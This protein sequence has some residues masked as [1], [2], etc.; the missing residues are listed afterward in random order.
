MTTEPNLDAALDSLTFAALRQHSANSVQHRAFVPLEVV[1]DDR[2]VSTLPDCVDQ[3]Q[4]LML[5]GEPGAGKTELARWVSSC[6]Q[7]AYLHG[8]RRGCPLLLDARSLAGVASVGHLASRLADQLRYF[9]QAVRADQVSMLISDR[10]VELIVDGLDELPTAHDRVNIVTVVRMLVS[11]GVLAWLTTRPID[12]LPPHGLTEARIWPLTDGQVKALFAQFVRESL[13]PLETGDRNDDEVATLQRIIDRYEQ[14]D[15]DSKG[16][17]R[18]PL[19]ARLFYLEESARKDSSFTIT[20]IYTDRVEALLRRSARQ[21][22]ARPQRLALSIADILYIFQTASA[23]AFAAGSSVLT[24]DDLLSVVDLTGSRADELIDICANQSGLLTPV[25]THSYAFIHKTFF[26]FFVARALSTDLTDPLTIIEHDTILVFLCGLASDPAGVIA[27]VMDYRGVVLT[28]RCLRELSQMGRQT[29]HVLIDRLLSLIDGGI[30]PLLGRALSENVASLPPRSV[31]GRFRGPGKKR[32]DEQWM[33]ARSS[34]S[35]NE[36]GRAF[37]LFAVEYF[38]TFFEVVRHDLRTDLGQIDLLLENH[39]DGLF[40][41]DLGG[42]ALVECKNLRARATISDVNAFLAKVHKRLRFS[43]IVSASGFT[44]DARDRLKL[45]VGE[46]GPLVVP[47]DGDDIRPFLGADVES[48][49][50]HFKRLIRR[51]RNLERF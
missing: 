20:S 4:G 15:V 12:T 18:T 7:R 2:V 37:E 9:G 41:T 17:L 49:E 31:T 1:I 43:F 13:T 21:R 50:A 34:E 48:P 19:A 6:L 25:A 30:A 47:I 5:I 51:M 24:R 11:T 23:R 16:Y 38:G 27:A 45:A 44:S 46:S 39:A 33:I 26:E 29:Q 36:R 10:R 3:Y 42:D 28:R 32:L 8:R 22:E 14:L 35:S 40:W